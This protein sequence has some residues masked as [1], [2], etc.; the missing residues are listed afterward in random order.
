MTQLLILSVSAGNG[1]VRAAQALEAAARSFA[2]H[3][4]THLDAMD[5]VWGGLR[6]VYT[7]GY[8][9]LV[10]RAPRSAA[11]RRTARRSSVATTAP[12]CAA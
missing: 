10:A 12:R 11:R 7:Q 3:T 8:A 5:F 6:Q 9:G 4:A 1:H 2:P